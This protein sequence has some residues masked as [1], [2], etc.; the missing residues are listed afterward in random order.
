MFEAEQR[1]HLYDV[2]ERYEAKNFKTV[3]WDTEKYGVDFR[4]MHGLTPLMMAA[5]A[6]N[7]PLVEALASRGA[8]PT[9]RSPYGLQPLHWALRRA[10]GDAAFA[11]SSFGAMWRVLA[12]PSF[13]VKVGVS[14]VQIGREQGEFF[15]FQAMIE[16]L[17]QADWST[18]AVMI[19]LGAQ[20]FLAGLETFSE[21]VIREYRKKRPYLS[22]LLSK[23]EINGSALTNR[24]PFKRMT[25]G[26]YVINPEAA[27]LDELG[28]G[29]DVWVPV[30]QV[31]DEPLRAHA[32]KMIV[33]VRHAP[34]SS[35]ATQSSR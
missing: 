4:S 13:D 6:G 32:L 10:W 12:P 14:T 3:L 28:G 23:N 27:L 8:S 17:W 22:H 18:R 20:H 2:F 19:G 24:R 31:L 11:R 7:L 1:T 29:N 34:A 35:S 21:V 15:V 25:Q 33:A 9:A 30:A 5:V 26:R 16:R